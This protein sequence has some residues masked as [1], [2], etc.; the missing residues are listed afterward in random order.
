[1]AQQLNIQDLKIESTSFEN[2]SRM[3]DRHTAEGE[4]IPP[5]LVWSGVPEGTKS[6]ALIAH[7]PDAP[8]V[9][10]FTHWVAYNFPGDSTATGETSPVPPTA[11]IPP[12]RIP[13]WVQ[14]HHLVTART[15]T[16][17]G[18]TPSMKILTS[19]LV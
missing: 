12:A 8:L 11:R 18:C 16:T 19:S 9:D 14:R 15:T 3:P 4:D 6:L 1:M 10:G 5:E 17:S 2:H 7:D 13:T